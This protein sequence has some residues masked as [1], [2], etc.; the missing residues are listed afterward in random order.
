[1]R[2]PEQDLVVPPSAR[3]VVWARRRRTAAAHWTTFRRN[4][5]GI[6]GLVVLSVFGLIAIFAPLLVDETQLEP[7]TAS[8]PPLHPPSLQYP[9]GTDNFGRPV[10]GLIVMGSRISLL[11]GL[12]A[13]F[14]AIVIG[15][16][17][18][19]TAGGWGGGGRSGLIRA[20]TGLRRAVAGAGGG[21]LAHRD[22]SHPA[23][24]DADRLRERRPD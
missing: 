16:L 24:R 10:L 22:A 11:V 3:A 9:L 1:M 23:Q 21:A 4:R 15:A 12:T 17:V 2:E 20:R 19:G 7:A 14:G 6:V 18:G 8:A 13:T 5:Q